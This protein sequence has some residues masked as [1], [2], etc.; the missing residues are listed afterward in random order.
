[1]AQQLAVCSAAP[2]CL[3][4]E[5]AGKCN[6]RNQ[7]AGRR[8]DQGRMRSHS[9]SLN[10]TQQHWETPALSSWHPFPLVRQCVTLLVQ[11]FLSKKARAAARGQQVFL[12]GV[13]GL[14]RA[15]SQALCYLEPTGQRA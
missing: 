7:A 6:G 2:F 9:K 10:T 3:S 12:I 14:T 11:A 4:N 1:M 8:L 13:P 15:F 5:I